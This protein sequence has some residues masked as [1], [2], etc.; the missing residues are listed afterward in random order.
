ML[1]SP[2]LSPNSSARLPFS[3]PPTKTFSRPPT[4]W[5]RHRPNQVVNNMIFKM[6]TRRLIANLNEDKTYMLYKITGQARR[7]RHGQ[8][9]S[10][11]RFSASLKILSQLSLMMALHY[12]FKCL[13]LCSSPGKSRVLLLCSFY[14]LYLSLSSMYLYIV[15]IFLFFALGPS[16]VCLFFSFTSLHFNLYYLPDILYASMLYGV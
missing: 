13:L 12:Y 16:H 11:R 10:Q 3:A 1:N 8:H 9:T 5:N 2:K 7:L 15:Y 14:F 4:R 6:L